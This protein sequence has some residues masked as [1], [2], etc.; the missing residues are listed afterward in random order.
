MTQWVGNDIAVD[1]P[2]LKRLSCGSPT[3]RHPGAYGVD[4]G[5]AFHMDHR[6]SYFRAPSIYRV[7]VCKHGLSTVDIEATVHVAETGIVEDLDVRRA[8]LHALHPVSPGAVKDTVL[9][10]QVLNANHADASGIVRRKH[11]W[12]CKVFAFAMEPVDADVFGLIGYQEQVIVIATRG[13]A[14]HPVNSTTLVHVDHGVR[15]N[16]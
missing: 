16:G 1:S 4:D 12:S 3:N 13:V 14:A 9:D 8:L 5:V 6:P 2:T 15:W 10:G 7:V 11:Q